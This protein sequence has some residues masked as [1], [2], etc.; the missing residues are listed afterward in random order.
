MLTIPEYIKRIKIMS[1]QAQSMTDEE[2]TL[3]INDAIQIVKTTC[4]LE[5]NPLFDIAVTY[6][7]C[8][9]IAVRRLE[10]GNTTENGEMRIKKEEVS[11]TTIEYFDDKDTSSENSYLTTPFG[12]QYYDL[13]LQICGVETSNKKDV[14][15]LLN[16]DKC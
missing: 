10:A 5:T 1:L 16:P 6:L 7:V 14:F 11:N 13:I 3:I 4:L 2:L 12:K 9:L 8:H 15:T